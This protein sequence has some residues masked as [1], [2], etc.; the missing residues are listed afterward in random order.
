MALVWSTT[1][2]HALHHGIKICV[3]GDAGA[4]KTKLIETAPR[5][6]IATAEG[7]TLSIAAAS[8]RMANIATL[9]DFQ[10]FYAWCVQSAEAK[11]Y[12][13]VCVDSISEIAQRILGVEKAGLK[14]GRKAYGEM[15]DQINMM[16]RYYVDMPGKHLY[17][18][19][20]AAMIE[21]PEGGKMWGPMLP[22]KQLAKDIPFLFDEF[23]HLDVGEVISTQPNVPNTKYRFLRT[24]RDTMYQAKDRS[25]ALAAVEKPDLTYIFDK[26]RRHVGVAA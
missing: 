4:G 1:S 20:K 6:I 18:T 23:F 22:G 17:M 24:A 16:I 9:K 7:G 19:C 10:D 26:I 14:D 2:H 3:Y 8:I 15:Q 21:T 13:T 25:G 12:D 5:P 11:G